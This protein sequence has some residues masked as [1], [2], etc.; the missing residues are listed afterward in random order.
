[1]RRTFIV[2][3]WFVALAGAASTVGAQDQVVTVTIDSLTLTVGGEGSVNLHVADYPEPGLPAW[4]IDIS[5][6]G[7]VLSVIECSPSGN[8]V[9]QTD[10]REATI[11]VTG[12]TEKGLVGDFALA[13]IRFRCHDHGRSSLTLT[14]EVFGPAIGFP[15]E[16]EVLD[17]AI[18]CEEATEATATG[19]ASRSATP[20]PQ[21]PPTGTAGRS[22][23]TD[24]RWL[25]TAAAAAGLAA[26]AFAGLY[27]ASRAAGDRVV[28]PES[29]ERADHR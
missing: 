17:G 7:Q 25:A 8:A 19:V 1:M 27:M 9:C 28:L 12:A 18:V 6:D 11:R 24:Q 15:P 23:A 14:L 3:V 13:A 26:A 20:P 29:R 5:Y 10:Y 21:L 2:L 4:T 22:N 16:A